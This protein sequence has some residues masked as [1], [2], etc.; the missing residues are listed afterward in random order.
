MKV[1]KVYSHFNNQNYEE[2]QNEIAYFDD[3]KDAKAY[4]DKLNTINEKYA[5]TKYSHKFDYMKIQ[6]DKTPIVEYLNIKVDVVY[7]K[8]AY[9]GESGLFDKPGFEF[10]KDGYISIDKD[11]MIKIISKEVDVLSN[12]PYIELPSLLYENMKTIR[13]RKS[14]ILHRWIQNSMSIAF[15]EFP[16]FLKEDESADEF[17]DRCYDTAT[18]LFKEEPHK[19]MYIP[20]RLN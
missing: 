11:W 10:K 14:K 19:E 15:F 5:Y 2:K 1:Y 4:C 3:E 18:K 16:M 17:N 9:K 13:D 7:A 8:G 12:V 6:I 20:I